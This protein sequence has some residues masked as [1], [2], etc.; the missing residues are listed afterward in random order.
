MARRR[1]AIREAILHLQAYPEIDFGAR[2]TADQL[3]GWVLGLVVGFHSPRRCAQGAVHVLAVAPRRSLLGPTRQASHS[4][5]RCLRERTDVSLPNMGQCLS[6]TRAR[7]HR[8]ANFAPTVAADGTSTGTGEQEEPEEEEEAESLLFPRFSRAKVDTESVARLLDDS[9]ADAKARMEQSLK[10]ESKRE[11]SSTH[12]SY[13]DAQEESQGSFRLSRSTSRSFSTSSEVD[14]LKST[15]ADLEEQVSV[16]ESEDDAIELLC[17]MADLRREM[18]IVAALRHPH[19]AQKIHSLL[20]RLES[21]IHRL[22]AYVLR[23]PSPDGFRRVRESSRGV[24]FQRGAAAR[25]RPVTERERHALPHRYLSFNSATFYDSGAVLKRES[26]VRDQ[27]GQL[28]IDP[29]RGDGR[30]L[31][32]SVVRGLAFYAGLYPGS[33]WSE[34][35]ER[36]EADILRYLCVREMRKHRDLFLRDQVVEEDFDEHL[37][38]LVHSDEFAG[39][40]E[41][42]ILGPLLQTPICVYMSTGDQ[43]DANAARSSSNERTKSSD[44]FLVAVYGRSFIA[45]PVSLRYQ[46][47]HYDLLLPRSDHELGKT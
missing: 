13:T 40:P 17:H 19:R 35:R 27:S 45:E 34:R 46:S 28:R 14:A 41:L 36:R 18:Q 33:K 2:G 1:S 11:R 26:T 44:L 21:L 39:E 20:I 38:R 42:L 29:T 7:G 5:H 25:V 22:Q 32:R 37:R 43:A 23:S 31:F 8:R 3:T 24:L 47:M 15:L 4:L 9:K 16:V 12:S 30:C 6:C 10:T